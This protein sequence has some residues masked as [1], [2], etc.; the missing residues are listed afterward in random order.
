MTKREGET[1]T[2]I[3]YCRFTPQV[4]TVA[5]DSTVQNQEPGAAFWPSL[6]VIE[7]WFL[8]PSSAAVTGVMVDH[9]WEHIVLHHNT[10]CNIMDQ[11]LS[12]FRDAFGF[13]FNILRSDRE[14]E[15][16]KD[17]KTFNYIQL[18]ICDSVPLAYCDGKC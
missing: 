6:W 17:Y 1:E 5:E 14:E 4:T 7:P 11:V 18:K 9:K 3:P 15:K 2:K 8:G 16:H 13:F 10:S 12:V